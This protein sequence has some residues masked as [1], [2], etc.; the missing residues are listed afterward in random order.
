MLVLKCANSKTLLFPLG[1]LELWVFVLSL[2]SLDSCWKSLLSRSQQR[3]QASCRHHQGCTAISL[4]ANFVLGS[5]C[6][7]LSPETSG[8][9]Y[10]QN[11]SSKPIY[12]FL[13]IFNISSNCFQCLHYFPLSHKN[14]LS[15]FMDSFPPL[16]PP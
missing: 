2:S 14:H 11:Q 6:C 16:L 5:R 13:F 4:S 15:L 7:A 1:E 12:V 9:V 3:G 8:S 10:W